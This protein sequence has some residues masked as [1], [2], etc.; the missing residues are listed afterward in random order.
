MTVTDGTVRVAMPE[1][2]LAA[3]LEASNSVTTQQDTSAT[4][5]RAAARAAPGDLQNRPSKDRITECF[6][7][8]VQWTKML[9]K[10]ADVEQRRADRFAIAAGVIAV[11]TGASI[12]PVVDTVDNLL[13][14]YL[15]AVPALIAAVLAVFPQVKNYGEMAGRAR[16]L[17]SS[18]GVIRG[19]LQDAVVDYDVFDAETL[20]AMVDDFGVLRAKKDQLR[21]LPLR[22]V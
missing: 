15:L 18:Y 19:R 2:L 13:V 3:L 9:P 12:Y 1:A 14:R 21:D 6:K 20:R 7:S 10:Y 22:P 5:P 16:E 17:A 4:G 11:L 8:A